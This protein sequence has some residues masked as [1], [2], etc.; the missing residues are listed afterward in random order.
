MDKIGK[1]EIATQKRVI[2]F[3]HDKL[4]YTYI[5]N[6]KDQENRNIDADKLMAW[7]T[8][9]G[10][11]SAIA[12]RAIDE[13]LKATGNLQEGLY[14]ANR[15]VYQLLKYGAK[16]KESADDTETT[17]YFINWGTPGE[18]LFEIAEEVT[19]VANNEKRPDLVIYLNGIAVAVIE[20][21]KS[22]VSVSNGIR[23]NLTNQREMFIQPFFTTMQFCMAGND[24][25]GLRYGTINTAEKYYLEWKSDGFKECPE[26][27]DDVD[28]YIEGICAAIPNK[29]DSALFAM[30]YKARFLNL[31]H[32]FLIFDKGQK[33]VCRYNQYYGIMRAQK[34][35]AS[36]KGGII[37]HTQGS[38]KSLT[39]VWLSK[40]LLANNPK[41]R[42]LIVTDRDE[43]D[44]QIEKTYKG[45]YET[46]VRTKSGAD[47]LS[48]LNSY[49]DRLLCSL[50]H[51]FGKRGGEATEKDYE[52]YIEELKASLPAGFKAKDDI[53]VF[54]DECH[55]TQS[56]K[57]HLAMKTIMPNAIFVG[58]TG[59]PLLKADKST[60]IEVF[61][62]YIHTY[63]FD[64]GVEDGVVLDLCYEYRDI[65]QD[66][67]SQ[68]KI[69]IWFESKT[70][71]LMPR[72]KAR[73]KQL[74]GNMQSVYSS[75]S[76]L[77]K[78]VC[79][80]IFDFATKARL[81]DGSGNAILVADS[82][83]TACK[84]YELFQQNDFR[85]CAVISSYEPSAGD[86]R[87]ETV[88]DEEETDAFEKYRIYLQMIGIDP[89]ATADN[90]G[91]AKKV[92]EYEAAAKKKFV[93]EPYN[94]KLLIV[95]DKLL[96]GFDAPPC[97]YLYIDKTMHDH[98]L[99]Q[100]I[101]RVNR[102]DGEGKDF[103]Y[104]VDY[105]QLF[106]DLSEAM[107]KYTSG[108]FEG[109]ADE[110][111]EGLLKDRKAEAQKRFNAI[112]DELAELCDGV[113][114][115]KEEL[116]YLHY[117]C[118]ENGVDVDNDE[119]YARI[120]ERLYRLVNSLIRSYAEVK[121]Q[122]VELGYS[123]T[124]QERYD[125]L[126]NFYVALKATIG[127][128][129][130]DFIDL[131]AYEP[132]MRYLIDNYIVA[133]GSKIIGDFD[134]FTLLDFILAQREKLDGEGK[135]TKEQESAAEA[136]ENN[137]RK[138]VVEKIVLNPKYY[139]K[140][141]AVLE[142]LILE[143]KQ[144]VISY[145]QLLD[146]YITLARNVMKPEENSE[147]YPEKV[148]GNAALRALYDNTGSDVDLAVT[149]HAAV[150]RSKMDRF[151]NDPV[152]ERR[153]KRE[154][155]KILNSKDEVERVFKIIVE[156]EEY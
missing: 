152:K 147:H 115:P 18:N 106:G 31:I 90:E 60:S 80:I 67:L 58:F 22:T 82:I 97:T 92:T 142:Q 26:E 20:L 148:R 41:A 25:E 81:S 14:A 32:N 42:V 150:L 114:A 4:H 78:I 75:R 127:R 108:A 21:K 86:L 133:E 111:V 128:S 123:D 19:V 95:V 2:D 69:D 70:R 34:R 126:V 156:Q 39:M 6:L 85:K 132:G 48:R 1:P 109:Y 64:E 136:I 105:K 51:K 28:V 72:A 134:D 17:V 116:D 125:K 151:R 79:D 131:K 118:G 153:I 45:V 43:L 73:L 71:G 29:L 120:R 13:L 100:A 91:I 61:G 57:L 112:L 141:S 146:K 99:F 117:F 52:R 113:S 35:L 50:I 87:T 130:G 135:S 129:S 98:G 143:R 8:G 55:R 3:F 36:G 93:E 122:M 46:I 30:F 137:I 15:E 40:W 27:R 38:G 54:V 74:W 9:H 145:S 7:L 76:R 66:I 138:K 59:T 68:D 44:E 154:L 33:K 104:I 88:S 155:L 16:V 121:P 144:G 83:L 102:L 5:G 110:D 84:Y 47:L 149:L 94:M 24:T 140:M 53:Y 11:T 63:K 77:E 119:A 89:E 65:P 124:E 10:Y 139:E 101:C 96:T 37:W 62:R 12:A 56:G 103:G 23:Q 49:E 107:E